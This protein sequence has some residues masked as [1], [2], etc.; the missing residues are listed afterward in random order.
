M[1]RDLDLV[2]FA[3]RVERLCDFFLSQLREEGNIPTTHDVKVL[4]DLKEDAGDIA[5]SRV[6][7]T[8]KSLEGLDSY[9]RGI[10][11]KKK[12]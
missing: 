4:E 3:E 10:P 5:C 7:I 12:E 6:S 11:E 8:Q 9:M 2:E 1:T